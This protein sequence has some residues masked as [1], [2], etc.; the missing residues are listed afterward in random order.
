MNVT[1]GK[2]RRVS[3]V[4]KETSA[5]AEVEE[6]SDLPSIPFLG[7]GVAMSAILAAH[8]YHE[9]GGYCAN[10]CGERAATLSVP[11][12]DGGHVRYRI[13]FPEAMRPAAERVE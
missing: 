5:A 12:S 6:R 7:V 2:N 10:R 8:G 11:Q 3:I 13:E 1:T 9:F 4:E